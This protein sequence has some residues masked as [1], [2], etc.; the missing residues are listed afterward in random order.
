MSPLSE[1]GAVP[2]DFCD[3][4]YKGPLLG[5][6]AKSGIGAGEPLGGSAR[7][8]LLPDMIAAKLQELLASRLAAELNG[9][10]QS[11]ER[12]QRGMTHAESRAEND[13]DTRAIESSYLARGLAQRVVELRNA[14]ATVQAWVL[15]APTPGETRIR[16]GALVKLVD[17]DSE[18]RQHLWLA[19]AGGGMRLEYE[20]QSI[21]VLSPQAPLAQALVGR[22][23]DD[24]IEVQSPSGQRLW[25]VESIQS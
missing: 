16:L 17:E 14:L 25:L 5:S 13:K 2:S 21:L 12:I 3:S 8:R 9:L 6:L 19:P 4:G 20:Q 10:T 15:P 22:A 23:V 1:L 7:L 24:E 11:Q 18:A